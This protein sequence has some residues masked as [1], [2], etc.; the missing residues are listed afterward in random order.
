MPEARPPGGVQLVLEVIDLA[1]ELFALTLP[2]LA[3][4]F[5]SLVLTSQPFVLATKIVGGSRWRLAFR[6]A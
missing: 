3:L 1:A 5:E 4:F 6:H 2:A